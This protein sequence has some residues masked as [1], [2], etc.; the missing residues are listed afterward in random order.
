MRLAFVTSLIPVARPDTGFEIAN[1]AII[2]AL[3]AAGHDVTVFGFARPD[4]VLRD[5]HQAVLFDRMVIENSAADARR[6]ANWLAGALAL[7]LPIA[8]AKLK[9]AGGRSVVAAVKERG[10]W[11]AVLLNSV[12]MAGA[13]PALANIAPTILIEHNIE[14]A[15]AAQ[16]ARHAGGVAMRLLFDR[17]ARLLRRIE[18]KLWAQARFIWCLAEEDRLAL[19]EAHRSK[20]AVLPLLPAALDAPLP[21]TEIRHDLGL[22]GTWTWE[23]NLIGL[24][25]FLD[26]VAPYLTRGLKIAVAGRLPEGLRAPANVN[27][28]G[29]VPDANAF[30]AGCRVIAL[31]SRAGTGVQLKTIEALGHGLPA[32]ATTLSMRGLGAPPAN[33]AIADD[34]RAFA[35]ALEQQVTAVRDGRIGRIDGR[36]F[37]VA[38][39]NRLA[40]A[41]A[42]GLAAAA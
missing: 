4:D 2:D 38:Q 14:H 8:C 1:A 36:E 17:E 34:A 3:R 28:V 15:S 37:I 35:V 42:S 10:P 11:D 24:K 5:D 19:G 26:E 9:L 12:T 25:W 7:R 27:L 30:L 32:V 41:I 23:P 13:F 33:V 20:S 39:K 21:E 16:N 18:E 22:I 29:R 31:A 6:K 40:A